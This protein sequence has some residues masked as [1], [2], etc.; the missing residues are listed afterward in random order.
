VS[1]LRGSILVGCLCLAGLLAGI[2]AVI[3]PWVIGYPASSGGAWTSMTWASVW[4]GGV[5]VAASAAGLVVSTAVALA[6][7]TRQVRRS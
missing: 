3:A 4:V 1:G 5:V 2:W 7:L 6:A